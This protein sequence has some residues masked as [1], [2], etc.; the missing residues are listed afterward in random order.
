MVVVPV[1]MM[2]V[3]S[4]WDCGLGGIF[5]LRISYDPGWHPEEVNAPFASVVVDAAVWRSASRATLLAE[6]GTSDSAVWD[7]GPFR[8]SSCP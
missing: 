8:P 3:N 4:L 6:V 1:W 7:S 2:V 5:V